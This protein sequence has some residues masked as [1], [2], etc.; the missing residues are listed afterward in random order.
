MSRIRGP[1]PP[2]RTPP[3]SLEPRYD[4]N[5]LVSRSRGGHRRARREIVAILKALGDEQPTVSRTLVRGLVG[6][7]T[8]LASRDVV[9]GL[10]GLQEKDPLLVQY[11]C[12]WLP[13]DAWGSSDV[14]AMK[15]AIRGLRDRIEPTETWRMTLE[16]RR[17]TQH[18]QLEL[19]RILAESIDAKVDLTHPDKILRVDIL[20][21][22]AAMSVL[23]PDDIFS[24]ARPRP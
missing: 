21:R 9:R 8:R 15:D 18:H 1:D 5:L 14:E 24:T 7:K 23:T 6:V 17:Y 4:F 19:V 3:T 2:G 13:V 12:K 11:T 10:R 22:H 16:K 20:G